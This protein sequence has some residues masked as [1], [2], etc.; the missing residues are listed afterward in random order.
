MRKILNLRVYLQLIMYTLSFNM[1][2]Q[3]IDED[4]ETFTNKLDSIILNFRAE[5]L[6]ML[7]VPEFERVYGNQ[8]AYPARTGIIY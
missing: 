8:E 4:V 1:Q 7:K 2:P 6:E 3:I 5:V